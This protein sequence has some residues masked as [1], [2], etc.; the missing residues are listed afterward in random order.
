MRALRGAA[1]N[2]ER[3]GAPSGL[4]AAAATLHPV[5]VAT[6]APRTPIAASPIAM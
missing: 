2:W 4:L 1:A 6:P 3:H 5:R